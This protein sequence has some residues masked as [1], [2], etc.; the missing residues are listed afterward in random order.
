M[1]R[2][3]CFDGFLTSIGA[4]TSV[5]SQHSYKRHQEQR[6]SFLPKIFRRL[7]QRC[8]RLSR[9]LAYD[10]GGRQ[11]IV[12]QSHCF[13][14]ERDKFVGTSLLDSAQYLIAQALRFALS[15]FG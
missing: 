8:L 7:L 12:D 11:N 13:S 2:I 14:S 9:N 1:E 10:V 15:T 6:R 5:S 3:V 4:L